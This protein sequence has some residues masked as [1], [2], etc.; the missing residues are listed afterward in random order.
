MQVLFQDGKFQWKRL[1]NL[2]TLAREGAGQLLDLN[3]TVRDGL[4]L[5]LLDDR[6]RSQL[7]M[8]FTEEDRLHVDEVISLY[9]VI[10][11]LRSLLTHNNECQTAAC[12]TACAAVQTG[13]RSVVQ[14]NIFTLASKEL[15]SVSKAANC[16]IGAGLYL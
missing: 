11:C 15:T 6:L 4:R 16:S 5:V 1:E 12:I 3:D 9:Q 10:K 13:E 8:A 14:W 7:L 2:I